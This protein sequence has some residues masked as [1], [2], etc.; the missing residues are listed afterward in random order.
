MDLAKDFAWQKIL[1]GRSTNLK[2]KKSLF[3]FSLLSPPILSHFPIPSERIKL[4]LIILILNGRS[5]DKK[6]YKFFFS[7]IFL[8]LISS[9]TR[10]FRFFYQSTSQTTITGNSIFQY[11]RP[12][13]AVG[14]LPVWK[15]STH[16]RAAFL[17]DFQKGLSIVRGLNVTNDAAECGVALIQSFNSSITTDGKQKQFLLQIVE[18]HRRSLSNSNKSKLVQNFEDLQ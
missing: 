2:I 17:Q 8:P 12:K 14:A 5:T 6:N 7:P 15:C 1:S 11:K 16:P 3:S 9:L 10:K 4:Q 18:E 13:R